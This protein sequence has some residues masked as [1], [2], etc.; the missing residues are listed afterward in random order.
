[1]RQT[2]PMAIGPAVF[3]AYVA[4]MAAGGVMGFVKAK[5]KASLIASWTIAA[6]LAVANLLT[7]PTAVLVGMFG[8]LGVYFGFKFAKGRK[9]MPGGVFCVLSFLAGAVVYLTGAR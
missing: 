9:L 3:W 2:E 4:L 7:A 8:F 1:M 5:S 6:V